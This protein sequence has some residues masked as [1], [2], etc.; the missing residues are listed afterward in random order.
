MTTT[1]TDRQPV[2]YLSHGAPPLADDARWTAELASWSTDLPRPSSILI[3]SAHWELAPDGRLGDLGRRPAPLRLL[4]LPPALLRGDLRRAGRPRAGALGRRAAVRRRRDAAPGPVP[5][6]R[7]RCLRAAQ[8]DVPR[9]RRP[10]APA[11]DAD[12]GPAAA[13]RA[14]ASGSPRCATRTCSSSG[15][16]FTTHNLAWFNPARRPG[17]ARRPPRPRSSTTGRPRPWVGAT[18]TRCSTSSPRPRR[19]ARRTRARSTGRRSTSRWARRPPRAGW[20][21]ESVIDGFWFGLSKRSWQ[22][23]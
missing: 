2:L 15:S 21:R 9:G 14:R 1:A 20:T 19:P 10:G 17:R 12:A 11:V 22:F 18:S 23:A 7:P 13:V 6:A 8:G 16:G 5:R 4:G 3:V